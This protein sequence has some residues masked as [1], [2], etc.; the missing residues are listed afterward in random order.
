LRGAASLRLRDEV[1]PSS[2]GI[3]AS[4]ALHALFSATLALRP[5]PRLTLARDGES[6]VGFEFLVGDP[7]PRERRDEPGLPVVHRLSRRNSEPP[8]AL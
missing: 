3:P 8:N 2:S 5:L 1:S 7:V 4:L 6:V